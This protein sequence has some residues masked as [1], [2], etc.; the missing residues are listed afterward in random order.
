CK[1][2]TS[3]LFAELKEPYGNQT[4]FPVGGTVEYV[5]RP[6]YTQHRGMPMVITCLRNQTWSVAPEFCKRKQCENPGDPENGRA[7]VLT[8]LLLGSKVNYT[9]DKG[10]KLVGGSQRTC[11]VSGTRVSWSGDAP[12]CQR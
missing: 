11:K 12:V 1:A 3:L 9:C 10:Y 6:G 5:C 2:P 7:L 4:V 8:D